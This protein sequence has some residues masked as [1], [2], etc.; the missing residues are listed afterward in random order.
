MQKFLE[1]LDKIAGI[2][3]GNAMVSWLERGAFVFL[4]LMLAAAPHSI[5]A[6]QTAWIIGMLLWV[7]RLAIRPRLRLKFGLLDAALWSFFGWSVISSVFSYEP[8]TSFDRLRGVA[9]FLIVYFVLHNLR[10]MRA[11][12][13]AVA[14]LISSCMINVVWTPVQRLIG[15]GVAVYGV[16]PDS[17]LAKATIVDGDALFEVNGKK[18]RTPDEAFSALEQTETS[19]VKA[20]RADF[21]IAVPVQRSDLLP[22]ITPEQRL[23]FTSWGRTHTWRSSGFYGHYTTYAEVLQMIASL[24]LGLLVAGFFS[25]RK[26]EHT[27]GRKDRRRLVFVLLS[28]SLAGICLALLLTVTRA[29]QLAFLV[30]GLVICL[31]GASR[32]WLM[33]ALAAGIPVVLI[34][35]FILQQS[36]DVGFFDR[37]DLSTQYRQMMWNDG[38]R[39]WSETPRHLIV[40]VGM[41]SIQKH[42]QEWNLFD[43]GWQP[44]GHFHS[45]PIQLLVERGLPALL[46][47]L[48]VLGVYARTLWREI[49]RTKN[50]I[51]TAA[52]SDWRPMGTL[53][54][55]FGGM[56]GFFT[57]GLVHYNLGD[58]EVAMVFFVLMGTG[59]AVIRCGQRLDGNA[60]AVTG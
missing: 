6:T 49:N 17:P 45:T 11:V 41:D 23:G 48:T 58:Q 1:R 57:S 40:G 59:L 32:R 22:G 35:L 55:C 43:K 10:N 24:V 27:D 16:Q 56:I 14:V 9:L 13:F 8:P 5:A 60:D 47:W 44:M 38:V 33:V 21:E 25:G 15:R 54:G 36:R 3:T 4:I 46:L 26:F 39:L 31:L 12:Y 50:P 34:G 18:V 29:S 37:N 30:S 42:W 53:L 28:G 51:A 7:A 19:N 52:G 20:Y 2:E